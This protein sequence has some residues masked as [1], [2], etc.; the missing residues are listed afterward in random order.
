MWEIIPLIPII[1]LFI[2][3]IMFVFAHKK[4]ANAQQEMAK[5]IGEIAK[6]LKKE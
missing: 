1:G 3:F 2:L 4:L 6:S 5:H